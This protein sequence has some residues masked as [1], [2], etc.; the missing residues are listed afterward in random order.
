M[1]ITKSK[2]CIKCPGRIRL[3]AGC[4]RNDVTQKVCPKC[5]QVYVKSRL[6]LERQPNR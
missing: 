4:L 1:I 3:I 5:G 6:D 2:I